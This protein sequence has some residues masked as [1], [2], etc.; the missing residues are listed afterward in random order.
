MIDRAATRS[1][2]EAPYGCSSATHLPPQESKDASA[3][4]RYAAASASEMPWLHLPRTASS[5]APAKRRG[6]T[7]AARARRYRRT[8]TATSTAEFAW[9]T[10]MPLASLC[11]L[12]HAPSSQSNAITTPKV[13]AT[14]RRLAGCSTT[15]R[16]TCPTSLAA[17]INARSAVSASLAL[18]APTRHAPA[19]LP[20][21]HE[22]IGSAP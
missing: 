17:W 15:R 11:A 8:A 9:P 4:Y 18:T 20:G 10:P 7:T 5:S 21:L 22:S 3:S 13:A 6:A 2:R 12:A 16:S 14:A 1:R 19:A